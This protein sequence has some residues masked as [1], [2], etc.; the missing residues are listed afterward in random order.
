MENETGLPASE[1]DQAGAGDPGLL[2]TYSRTVV[3]TVAR[4]GPAV[5]AISIRRR[6]ADRSGRVHEVAGAGSGFAFT[7]DGFV[8]TNSH[9]VHGASSVHVVFP[10][11]AEFDADPI[12]DDPATD[13]AVVRVGGSGLATARLGRS[14]KLRVGQLAIAIGNPYGFENTVTAG[15]VS[16]LGRSLPA[17]DGNPI[18]DLIQ[19][20]AALNPGNSGG[21]LVNSA[22]EV[23]GVNT[24]IIP[25]AQALCFAIG[26]DT[27]HW[28]VM[29]LLAHGR[30]RRAFIGLTGATASIPRL[31]QRAIGVEQAQGV[32]VGEVAP[33]SPARTAG[34]EPGDLII[35]LDGVRIASIGE[36]RRL[37]DH[38]RI[39]RV[40]AVRTVRGGK[41]LHPVITPREQR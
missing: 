14:A 40:C 31:V 3:D 18:E 6:L 15:V 9:V 28:V 25:G 27:A 35:G 36:L 24:A 1:P 4:V 39:G 5:G 23:I 38:T 20:D 17:Q 30:V 11:G 19:T 32:R 34:I 7:P 10:D 26:V 41:L 21:P 22:S 33:D 16:A 12:G 37:L 13:L 2:D 8:L 29:Q